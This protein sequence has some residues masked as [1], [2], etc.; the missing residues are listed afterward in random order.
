MYVFGMYFSSK[1]LPL[2]GKGKV[3]YWFCGGLAVG[4][5]K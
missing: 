2:R 3:A 5:S 4:E 1:R